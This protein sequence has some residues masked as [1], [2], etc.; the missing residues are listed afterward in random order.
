M[1]KFSKFL[2]EYTKPI[3]DERLNEGGGF[4]HLNSPQH[5]N[6]SLGD[7]VSIIKSGFNGTLETVAEKTD[8][9]NLMISWRDGKLIAS[10]NK[11]HQKDY[12]SNALTK[13]G[14]YDMFKGRGEL[15]KAFNNAVDDLDSGLGKLSNDDLEEIFENG[16]NWASLEI[17]TPS[18]ENIIHYGLHELRIHGILEL[19]ISGNPVKQLN[20]S[21]GRYI[22]KLLKTINADTQKTY[23][24]KGLTKLN[25][26]KVKNA[27]K[28]LEKYSSQLSSLFS[29]NKLNKSS[30]INDYK[31]KE[32]EKILVKT[33]LKEITKDALLNRWVNNDKSLTITKIYKFEDPSMKSTIQSLDKGIKKTFGEIMKPIDTIFLSVGSIIVANIKTFMTVHPDKAIRKIRD[34]MANT[35]DKI[36]ASDNQQLKDDLKKQ[37]ERIDSVGIDII[38]PSEGITF[39]YKGELLK[40]TG[41][42]AAQNALINLAWRL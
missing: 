26:S 13:Q 3:I 22:A 6:Y 28:E 16:K 30:T 41:L 7:L 20:Q 14:M 17:M 38:S 37:Q 39:F 1:K 12:G 4:G 35:T 18:N 11:G 8:G 40:F 42:F 5:V 21:T 2:E 32:I 24:I 36:T 9:Q 10:R 27:D 25:L 33:D 31:T 19:D 34:S 15:S 29:K 23:E